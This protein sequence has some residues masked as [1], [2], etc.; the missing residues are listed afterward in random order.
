[1]GVIHQGLHPGE[2]GD[3]AS[4]LGMLVCQLY[5]L[6]RELRAPSSL[7]SQGPCRFAWHDLG[8]RP[9]ALGSHRQDP[10]SASRGESADCFEDCLACALFGIF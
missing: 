1:M 6:P 9:S 5:E 10:I 8:A 2:R 7:V 4:D 3:G